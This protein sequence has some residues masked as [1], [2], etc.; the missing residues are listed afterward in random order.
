[1]RELDAHVC[2][3]F[4]LQA[5]TNDVYGGGGGGGGAYLCIWDGKTSTDDIKSIVLRGFLF[6]RPE[7]DLTKKQVVPSLPYFDLDSGTK[8]NFLCVGYFRNDNTSVPVATVRGKKWSFVLGE[9]IAWKN[10]FQNKSSWKYSGGVDLILCNEMQSGPYSWIDL[11]SSVCVS[12]DDLLHKKYI[13]SFETFFQRV[14]NFANDY[15]GD[16]PSWDFSDKQG[17]RLA[18]QTL[19]EAIINFL[20]KPFHKTVSEAQ[21]FAVRNITK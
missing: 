7:S 18:G 17:V 15:K 10:E 20:P 9:F 5:E 12:I 8:F 19:K 21:Y 6:A 11:K 3:P 13:R 16:R 1:M 14:V 4:R 2:P